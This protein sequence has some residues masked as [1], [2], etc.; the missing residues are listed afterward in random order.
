MHSLRKVIFYLFAALFFLVPLVLWPFTSEVFEFNKMVL[1]YI[2]TVLIV[3]AWVTRSILEE[4]FVF[5]RTILDKPLLIFLGSQLIS[6]IL[7]I[8]PLTSWLGYYSR[9]N[10][11]FISSLSYSLLY[12]AFVSNFN[13]KDAVNLVNF[14]VFPGAAIVAL[15]GVAEHFGIDKSIWV[16]DVQSRVFSTLGQ[17][18]WLSAWLVALIPILWA[19]L[20][21]SKF[22]STK[23]WLYF[24]LSVLFFWTLIFTKSRSG[25]LGFAVAFAT[26]WGFYFLQRNNKNIT[27]FAII[28]T[29][30]LVISLISGTQYS[31]SLSSLIGASP[32]QSDTKSKGPVLET[33]GTESGTIRGIVWKGAFDIWAHY[34]VFGTGV[35]TFAFSYYKFRPAEHNLTSEWDFIY[36]KAHNEFLNMAANSGTV[37]LA[38]YLYLIG[39]SIFI[40]IN[41]TRS[42]I[43]GESLYLQIAL[44][45]GYVSLSVTNFFGFSVVPTQLQFFLFPAFAVALS[46]N[47]TEKTKNGKILLAGMQKILIFILLPLALYLLL[48][49]CRY[50]LAD[51]NFAKGKAVS[52]AGQ[53]DVGASYIVKALEYEPNQAIYHNA[54][55]GSYI[56]IA[57]Y[58]NKEK[59]D[60]NLQKFADLATTESDKALSL[61]PANM[62]VR[63]TRFGVYIMLAGIEPKYLTRARDTIIE[64][65]TYAPTDAKL[66]YNLGLVYARTD[67]PDKAIETFK[68]TIELKANYKEPRLALAY[69]LIDKKEYPEAKAQLEYI[70]K[71]ID[72]NDSLTKQALESVR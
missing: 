37:G 72:P 5:R 47:E 49:I 63:R 22:R 10:G 66:Y 57:L 33:G 29:S 27:P 58:Y 8:D 23:F 31:P 9:F 14:A 43:D 11:G 13:R 34:P 15:F 36:N 60:E 42:I 16:Q 30:L 50:W 53:P 56:S 44:L 1:V 54:L 68:K 41:K 64:A 67:D 19:F 39:A 69:L 17:P 28:V 24:S 2:L 18:N 21:S 59:D 3:S 38:A 12:W 6:T 65:I 20:F 70:L 46:M 52:D 35:E 45:A 55:A 40:F 26:F 71:Y 62:N 4:K 25:L 51:I 32:A 61:S 48:L 7:S